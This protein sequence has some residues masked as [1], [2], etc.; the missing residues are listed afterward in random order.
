MIE[1]LKWTRAST[2]P[3]EGEAV[4]CLSV[5]DYGDVKYCNFENGPYY[6]DGEEYYG[7]DD[8]GSKVYKWVS[9]W[10][11]WEDLWKVILEIPR[12]QLKEDNL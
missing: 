11:P 7:Y 2:P 8:W 3:K 6:W 5:N 10:M 9:Y 1:G 4:A 12:E